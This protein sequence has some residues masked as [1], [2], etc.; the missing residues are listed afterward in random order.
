MLMMIPVLTYNIANV[1]RTVLGYHPVNTID[2]GLLADIYMA[3]DGIY[4]NPNLYVGINREVTTADIITFIH[5]N[6]FL[7]SY[8]ML[9]RL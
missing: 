6:P 2:T 1:N 3:D 9:Q 5:G 7:S 8:N 4:S